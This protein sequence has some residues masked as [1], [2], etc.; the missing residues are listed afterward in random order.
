VGPAKAAFVMSISCYSE[1]QKTRTL[2]LGRQIKIENW[3]VGKE[4]FLFVVVCSQ[5][6]NLI[7]YPSTSG[8]LI[9]KYRHRSKDKIAL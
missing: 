5:P 8:G 1:I 9:E 4:Q 3:R 7:Q 6:A 2:K